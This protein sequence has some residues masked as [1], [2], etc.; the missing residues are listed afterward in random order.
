MSRLFTLLLG[1]LGAVNVGATLN[2]GRS[3]VAPNILEGKPD[4]S[5]NVSRI[6]PLCSTAS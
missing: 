3:K 2:P 1:L 5:C 6:F 4:G